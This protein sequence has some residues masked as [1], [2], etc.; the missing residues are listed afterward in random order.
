MKTLK[1]FF[2]LLALLMIPCIAGAAWTITAAIPTTASDSISG[3]EVWNNGQIVY[4]VRITVVSDGSDPA[5]FSL[6]D[7]LSA[8]SMDKIRGGVW[9]GNVINGDDTNAPTTFTLAVDNYAG[10]DLGDIATTETTKAE[11]FG[12]S[13][14][15]GDD[16][17]VVYDPQFDFPDIGDNLDTVVLDMIII[18]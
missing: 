10:A 12:A 1:T 4:I 9:T 6:S 7:Y 15:F 5:E 17:I 14:D 8:A 13:T 3:T 11:Y 18:K 2:V 16:S